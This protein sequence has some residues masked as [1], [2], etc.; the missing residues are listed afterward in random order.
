ME[1]EVLSFFNKYKIN[2]NEEDTAI[3]EEKIFGIPVAEFT[4]EIL[5]YLIDNKI[6]ITELAHMEL[7]EK[8]LV[9]LIKYDSMPVYRLAYKYYTDDNFSKEKF[10]AFFKQ[11]LN[12]YPDIVSILLDLQEDSLKKDQLIKLCTESNNSCI[13]KYGE[14]YSL[15][16]C[17]EKLDDPIKISRFYKENSD[18]SIIVKAVAQNSFTSLELLMILQKIKKVK[19]AKSIRMLAQENLKK[20]TK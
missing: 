7:P 10:R 16:E 17:V 4:D 14:S 5:E 1:K 9:R 19:D 15:A 18:N 11:Y 2:P 6:A 3:L 12:D 13:K 8:W 20:R